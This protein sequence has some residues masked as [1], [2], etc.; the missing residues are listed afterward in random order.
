MTATPVA[1]ACHPRLKG[2][3][4]QRRPGSSLERSDAGR[5]V[6]AA[7]AMIASPKVLSADASVSDV[8][9][10][11]EDDH[12]VMVLLAEGD[13]LL[14]TL[15]RE[16]VPDTFPASGLAL[17]LSTTTGRIVLPTEPI[18]AVLRRLQEADTRRLAVVD[19]AG[20]L[21]GLVCLK[22]SRTG[23]CRDADVA[24]RS[25]AIPVRGT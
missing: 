7:N 24:A 13:S 1:P 15:L 23:F 18:A 19:G 6:T 9:R 12:V 10:L 3:S 22:R 16:D 4:V 11:F 2:G 21:L 25:G 5:A 14:G 17:P 20:R 8:R